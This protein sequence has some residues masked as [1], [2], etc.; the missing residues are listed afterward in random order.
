MFVIWVLG[1]GVFNSCTS[2]D[3]FP[4]LGDNVASPLTIAV[5]SVNNRAYLNNSN[6]R[7][8]YDWEQA[9][10][11]VLDIATPTAPALLQTID[12][13]PFSGELFLDAAG[14]RLLLTNRL[15]SGPEVTTD[16][17][18]S[19]DLTSFA[20]TSFDTAKDPFGIACCD[21]S[22]RMVVTSR[23][24]QVQLFDLGNNLA[25]QTVTLTQAL[26]S[27]ETLTSS[28]ATFVALS[29]QQAFVS[30]ENGGVLVLNLDDV[31]VSGANPVD[32]LILDITAPRGLAVAV[33]KLYVASREVENNVIVNRLF[34]LDVSSLTASSETTTLVKDKDDDGL[35]SASLEVG[36]DPQQVLAGTNSVFVSN[37]DAD[38][39]SV[40]NI[41]DNAKTDV[42]VGEEPFGMAL[43]SPAGVD[44]HLLVCNVQANT[45]SIIDLTTQSVVATYP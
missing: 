10:V 17:L 43:Y 9:S 16:H 44:T 35:L 27:G 3:V 39:V 15:S 45:V 34:V 30:R 31:G 24:N 13:D 22:N 37:Q 33:G 1:F 5:D 38:T 8:V 32:Y 25:A 29:G 19:M 14:N 4:D 7:V 26:S 36:T 40:I 6:S 11:Q 28:R 21:G 41:A 20:V 2:S 42:A 12:V 23:D 18:L